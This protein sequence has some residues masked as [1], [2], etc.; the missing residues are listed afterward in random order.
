MADYWDYNT[1]QITGLSRVRTGSPRK[2]IEIL[3][4]WNTKRSIAT[5]I[6][7]FSFFFFERNPDYA[8]FKVTVEGLMMPNRSQPGVLHRYIVIP[9]DAGAAGRISTCRGVWGDRAFY[10]LAMHVKDPVFSISL[11]LPDGEID[12]WWAMAYIEAPFGSM[13][14]CSFGKVQNPTLSIDSIL[15]YVSS[16][17]QDR[18]GF[19]DWR[20]GLTLL[21]ALLHW[22][23][24]GAYAAPSSTLNK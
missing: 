9:N 16:A 17:S 11:L 2:E 12:H 7:F 18:W 3:T 21:A 8:S 20:R 13:E 23:R 24:R 14:S 5:H 10:D 15:N 19:A 6:V 4:Y 1:G 22:C